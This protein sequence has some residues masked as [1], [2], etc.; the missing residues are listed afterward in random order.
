LAGA[1]LADD[2]LALVLG[3][4]PGKLLAVGLERADDVE[5][6]LGPADLGAAGADRPAVDP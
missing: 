2:V 1:T 5:L 6:F 3:D 4:A